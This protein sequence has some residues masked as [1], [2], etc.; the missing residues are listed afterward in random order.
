MTGG[1]HLLL[2]LGA[3]GLALLLGVVLG[4]GPVT[5]QDAAG[6]AAQ[7]R[8]LETRVEDLESQVAALRGAA[9]DDAQALEALVR[10][11]TAGRLDGRSVLVVTSPGARDSDVAAVTGALEDAGATITGGLR[12][13]AAYVDPAKAQSP[14]EDLSLR[15]VPP[16][17]DFPDGALPIERVGVV[18]ARSTVQAPDDDDP[19][20]GVDGDAAEVIAGLDELDAVRLDGTPGRLAELAVLVTGPGDSEEAWPALVGLLDA[21]DAGSS[22]AVLTGPGAA[23][24]GLLR[25]VRRGERAATDGPS[26][27]DSAGTALGSVAT[28][29]AL[30]EQLTGRSGD[31]GLGASARRVVPVVRGD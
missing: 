4:A 23:R 10:P 29:L 8:A 5:E 14:L 18:L 28:V 15:L 9:A 12:L 20:A 13:Q 21:L 24:T 16:E 11:L 2:S 6:S 22:G 25:D 1:R 31:Y 3:S 7:N 17:V 27:V 26:T 30:A 19:A